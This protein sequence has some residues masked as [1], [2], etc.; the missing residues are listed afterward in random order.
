MFFFR[1]SID[2]PDEILVTLP[3]N[4]KSY[5]KLV[6]NFL[7]MKEY[8]DKNLR[9]ISIKPRSLFILINF[10]YKFLKDFRRDKEV[11]LYDNFLLIFLR[12]YGL[13]TIQELEEN[14]FKSKK[15]I[16][17]NSSYLFESF[18]SFYFKKRGVPTSSLQHG[19]YY[20]YNNLTPFETINYENI[21]A[22]ELLCWSEFTINQIKSLVPKDVK[23][24]EDFYPLLRQS[25]VHKNNLGIDKVLVMLPRIKYKN[26]I[27][28]LLNI[29]KKSN[30]K[31]LIRAHPT[32]KKFVFKL[33][34]N[35]KNL[36]LDSQDHLDATLLAG[37][38]KFCISFNSTTV[39]ETMIYDQTIVQY[40][41]GND[42][43]F[44]DSL[45]HFS[46][47]DELEKIK[48]R[49]LRKLDNSYYYLNPGSN[50]R[51]ISKK[52]IVISGVNLRS[53]GPLSIS[54]DILSYVNSHL[55]EEYR[56]I[57]LVHSKQLYIN[58]N[59]EN[60]EFI[61]FPKSI[62]SYF[63]RFYIEYIYFKKLSKSFNPYLWFSIQDLSPNIVSKV[64]AVY[65]HNATLFYKV[66]WKEALFDRKFLL[67][68]FVYKWFY[69][70]NIKSNNYIVVQQ[71]WIRNEFSNIFNL[72]KE[73]IVVS[74]PAISD[75]KELITES[76]K[77][78][79]QYTFLYPSFPRVFKNFELICEAII[80]LN[81]SN[82]NLNYKVIFT[83]DGSENSYSKD[84]FKK[85][86]FINNIAFKG[87]LSRKDVYKLYLTS[88]CLVFP[89]KL[90]TWGL[91]ITEAKSANLPIIVSDLPYAHESIN[92][93]DRVLFFKPDSPQD[94]SNRMLQAINNQFERHTIKNPE[95]PF[96][97]NWENLFNILLNDKENKSLGGDI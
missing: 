31:F 40:V 29:L 94:L 8:S 84:L 62:E 79:E 35:Y 93:Y 70:I 85:Y 27:I 49:K 19:I 71:D 45:P 97:S 68:S 51:L 7:S 56:V 2:S 63:S 61:E 15:Y 59:L 1:Y 22:D 36:Q 44:I 58:F 50:F 20:Q 87:L 48:L 16:A 25:K 82:P 76:E 17:F 77:K 41:S 12:T 92:N 54:E 53:S 47:L 81:K 60:I 52:L 72:N 89:S 66:S 43:F 21:C 96:S 37:N 39:F 13:I 6:S 32:S 80:L 14:N 83:L 33:I 3:S 42:E 4:R 55:T 65:C 34:F 73:K 64:K 46:S 26:E 91:P 88:D 24:T 5:K 75:F 28:N 74:Y 67:Q 38:Y 23:L 30:E 90:E 69:S 57:A 95:G 86:S 78:D 10:S 11:S 18:L 9:N